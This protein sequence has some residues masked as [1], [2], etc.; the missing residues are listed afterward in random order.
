MRVLDHLAVLV[1]QTQSVALY[2]RSFADT[3]LRFVH[4]MH[5]V[6]TLH[7]AI[8]ELPAPRIVAFV[9]SGYHGYLESLLLDEQ[10][11]VCLIPGAWVRHIPSQHDTQRARFAVQLLEAHV[12][13]PIQLLRSAQQLPL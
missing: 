3:R 7:D 5:D 12:N 2:V 1:P 8:R 4:N 11:T 6:P 10:T 13:E 9:G